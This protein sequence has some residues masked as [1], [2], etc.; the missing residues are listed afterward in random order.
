M[1][2][3]SKCNAAQRE[4]ASWEKGP[5]LVLAGPGSGKTFTIVKH[6][7]FL[8]ERGISPEKIL[9]ITFTKEAAKSM[10]NRFQA[11][12]DLFYPVA[13]GTFHSIFFQILRESNSKERRLIY[14]R[15]KIQILSNLLKK[16]DESNSA[17]KEALR[18]EA[19]TL[20]NIFS[21]YKNT[22]VEDPEELNIPEEFQSC[23]WEIYADYQKKISELNAMDFDDILLECFQLLSMNDNQ[24]KKWQKRWQ[25]I[26]IDEFQDINPIQYQILKLLM[27]PPGNVFAVGDDD[28]SIYG[29]RGSEPK[30]L[31]TFE[32]EYRASKIHLNLNYRSVPIIIESSLKVMEE[33]KDRYHKELLSGRKDGEVGN[34]SLQMFD[35]AEKEATDIVENLKRMFV[36]NKGLPAN[37]CPSVAILFRTN[38][39][40]QT[41]SA[42]LRRENIPF[43]MKERQENIYE[44]FIVKDIMAY[45]LLAEGEFS[46]EFFLQIMNKPCRFISREALYEEETNPGIQKLKTQLNNMKHFTP[47]FA[48]QYICKAIGY[49]R[50]LRQLAAGK[51]EQWEEW[52][53]I[54]LW[55]KAE[56]THY[57]TAK[58]WQ[59][60]QWLYAQELENKNMDS[61]SF[62]KQKNN[63][64]FAVQLMTVH[65]A[66]GLEFDTVIIPDCNE[67]NFPYGRMPDEKA[68]EEERRIFYVAMTRAKNNLELSCLTG[69]KKS[70]RLPS[71]YL[72]PLL[73]SSSVS[74]SSSNSQLSKYSSKAS[75]TFSNSSSSSM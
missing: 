34:V 26:L 14:N 48:V 72:N 49:E 29:F 45:L 37:D 51:E 46:R 73:Y 11:S 24:R 50:Y 69:T 6:I 59:E 74:T 8:I 9:V 52:N 35:D 61:K 20:L 39:S 40:L 70:P 38:M 13:F 54:L 25:V 36:K 60:A 30:C 57:D 42:V 75:E 32:E 2:D 3:L 1:L 4:A 22:L 68:V 66:K 23:F 47:G 62:A 15:E 44:H 56:A 63:E 55:T 5:L 31:Q 17:K 21:F 10:Q 58:D 19:A 12:S 18:E 64:D 43:R 53:R 71:R 28:Q 16:F 7:Q 41:Y 67:G 65:G 33:G 27:P